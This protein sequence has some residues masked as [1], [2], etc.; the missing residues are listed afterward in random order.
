MA[1]VEPTVGQLFAAVSRDLS[2]LVR[3]EIEL[4]K[5]ELKDEDY[6]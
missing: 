4:A 6:K 5:S 1:T 2:L 3:S